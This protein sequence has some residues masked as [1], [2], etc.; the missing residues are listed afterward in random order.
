M[1][2]LFVTGSIGRSLISPLRKS[3]VTDSI[4][5][6]RVGEGEESDQAFGKSYLS[7]NTFMTNSVSWN[8]KPISTQPVEVKDLIVY[9]SGCG[10]K[11]TKKQD[12]FCS[13]CGNKF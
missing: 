11:K 6:G 13:S 5:T 9:C 1:L 2:S 12:L 10:K 3:V 7:F 4:E 8:I